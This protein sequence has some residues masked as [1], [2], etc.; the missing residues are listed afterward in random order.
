MTTERV[1]LQV[2]R[3]GVGA[4]NEADIDFARTFGGVP[5]NF[6]VFVLLN[7]GQEFCIYTRIP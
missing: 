1:R 6:V 5:S 7:Q 3:E 4:I 2:L